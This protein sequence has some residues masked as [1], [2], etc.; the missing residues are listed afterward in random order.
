MKV[1]TFF[2][3]SLFFLSLEAQKEEKNLQQLDTVVLNSFV[4]KKI[5]NSINRSQILNQAISSDDNSPTLTSFLTKESGLFIREYGRGMLSGISI[6][7]T[8]TSHTQILW[9]GIPLNSALNGQSDL[10][11]LYIENFNQLLLKKGGESVFYGSGAI[12]G[13]IIMNHQIFFKPKKIFENTLNYGSFQTIINTSKIT[14]SGKKYYLNLVLSGNFSQNNYT[15]PEKNFINNNGEYKG[16]DVALNAGIKISNKNQITLN[17]HYNFLDRNLSNTLST[18]SKDKLI[19]YNYRN[20]LAWK[21]QS[22]KIFNQLTTALMA[23]E[24]QYYFD[25]NKDDISRNSSTRYILK[26][27]TYFPVKKSEFIFGQ[28]FMHTTGIGDGIGKHSQNTEALYFSYKFNRKKWSGK[29]N[30][31]KEFHPLYKIPVLSSIYLNKKIGNYNLGINF[32]NNFRS[33]TYNDLYWNPGGNPDLK[34]EK[35]YTFEIYQNYHTHNFDLKFNLFHIQSKDLIQWKPT[36][37]GFWKPINIQEVKSQGV[38]LYF[39]YKLL[40]VKQNQLNLQAEYTFQNVTDLQTEKILTY[41]PRHLAHLSVLFKN[42]K[43]Q[44]EISARYTG[45]VYT[46]TSNTFYLKPYF[47]LDY[48]ILYKINNYIMA[49]GGIFNITNTYYETFP[50]RPQPGRNFNLNINFKIE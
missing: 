50:A 35:S 48:R 2:I 16:K 42:K 26:N 12:G 49:G 46:T 32:S 14:F 6:R 13:V 8:G 30:L 7:G 9:N 31:R 11:T 22:K 40:F 4:L 47:L 15:I 36:A 34:P 10:N 28:N 20:A 3:I 23:E 24:Y 27:E 43:I 38:E 18:V 1:L 39:L 44:T 19:T 29:L 41:V 25:K 45:K 37:N 5:E 33:P 17:T 21:Y